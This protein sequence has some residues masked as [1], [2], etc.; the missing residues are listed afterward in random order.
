ML[1]EASR[2]RS[3]LCLEEEPAHL[4]CEAS[5]GMHNWQ[6]KA[7]GALV[8]MAALGEEAGKIPWLEMRQRAGGWDTLGE[9]QNTP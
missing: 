3:S 6:L 8:W 7:S 4:I 5:Q 9:Q 1:E 2:G